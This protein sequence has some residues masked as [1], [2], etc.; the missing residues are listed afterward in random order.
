MNLYFAYG[1][2]MWDRQMGMRCPESKKLGIARLSG[3]R[4][5]ITT[6]GYAN[7][8][9]SAHDE[10]EGVLFE[11]SD[12]D[13]VSLDKFEGV[14]NGFYEKAKLPVMMGNKKAEALVY[15]DPIVEEG[16]T[17]EEYIHRIN[18]GLADAMLSDDY[19]AQVRKFIPV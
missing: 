11:I 6:R 10:V 17:K 4:W 5:I 13:E 16:A 19:V 18:S 3:Y 1:S 8:V 2:N 14:A 12:S 7:V 9:E 15:L